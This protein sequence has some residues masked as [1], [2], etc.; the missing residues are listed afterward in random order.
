MERIVVFFK[1]YR[2][3]TAWVV[4][5]LLAGGVGALLSGGFDIYKTINKP[6]L[7]PPAV[8]FPIVW[9]LL[10][11]MMGLS[12]GTVAVSR[13][14]DKP[15]ALKLYLL[16]LLINILWPVI[17]FRFYA[18]K[19]ACVWLALLIFTLLIVFRRFLGIEKKSAWLLLP[20]FA[21]SLFA[22]YLNFGVVALNS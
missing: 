14:L 7:S 9:T 3:Q 8:V 12:S 16:H 17:F 4:L 5:T 20:Y 11:I 22:L 21:W 15:S 2:T 6:P 10:Y 18:F 19:L 1:K 13:D